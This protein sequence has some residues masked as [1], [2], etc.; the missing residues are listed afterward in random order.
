MEM[1]LLNLKKNGLINDFFITDSYLT[2][3]PGDANFN[4]LWLQRVQNSRLIHHLSE[5][6][7]NEYLYDVD[8][9]LIGKKSYGVLDYDKTAVIQALNNCKVLVV[10]SQRLCGLLE[11]YAQ[12][13]LSTKTIICPN[14]FEYSRYPRTPQV[15]AGIWWASSDYAALSASREAVVNAISRFAQKNDLT[16]YCSGIVDEDIKNTFQKIIDLGNVPYWQ[17]KAVL[18]SLPVMIGVAPLETKANRA[19]LDFIN[20]KS[21]LKMTEFGGFGHPGVYSRA[22]PYLDTDLHTGVLVANAEDAW[23]DGLEFIYR[24]GWRQIAIEQRHIIELRHMDRLTRECWRRAIEPVI[25]QR[26]LS[27]KELKQGLPQP[28]L[29]GDNIMVIIKKIKSKLPRPV[30]KLVKKIILGGL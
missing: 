18:A 19:T 4:V 5:K 6:V 29:T 20:G 8:D 30:T 21:D 7:N 13:P 26:P 27:G 9:L 23:L 2:G 14:G 22:Q 1:P 28:P 12:L 17:H 3:V 16:V 10:T 24:Q 15:P 11:I 25:L